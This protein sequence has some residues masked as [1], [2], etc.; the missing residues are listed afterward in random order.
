MIVLHNLRP[1]SQRAC[2]VL[3]LVAML[4]PKEPF[5]GQRLKLLAGLLALALPALA[6]AKA[7]GWERSVV[8]VLADND[9][10]DS[11]STGTAFAINDAGHY[12]TNHHVIEL[13]L[14]RSGRVMI[15]QPQGSS[16]P[17]EHLAQVLW[18]S[19]ELDLAILQVASWRVE[20]L[21]LS[22]DEYVEL[23]QEVFAMGFPGA[24]DIF[25]VNNFALQPKN[26]KGIISARR[27]SPIVASGISVD[28]YETDSAI[29]SGNSGGPLIDTC[30]R[31][32]GVNQSK[33]LS[34]LMDGSMVDTSEGT[35][36]AIQVDV[37]KKVLREQ[38]VDFLEADAACAA[39]SAGKALPPWLLGL[40]LLIGAAILVMLYGYWQLRK[41]LPK[42]MKIN[43]QLVSEYWRKKVRENDVDDKVI[44]KDGKKYKYRRDPIT[45]AVVLVEVN[46]ASPSPDANGTGSIAELQALHPKLSNIK[47]HDN[48]SYS[49]GRSTGN[50][51]I[52]AFSDVSNQH[53]RLQLQA[54][55]V[56]LVDLDSTN[57]SFINNRQLTAHET[58][59]LACGNE[60]GIASINPAYRLRFAV[61]QQ[62]HEE[63]A[64]GTQR[65]GAA[66]SLKPKDG[67]TLA[68]I[69]LLTT[70]DISIGRGAKCTYSIPQDYA[71]VSRQH[72]RL[73]VPNGQRVELIDTSTN[74]VWVNGRRLKANTWV[75]LSIGDELSLGQDSKLTW[76][77]V[78]V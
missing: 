65:L 43:S 53:A 64:G 68:A 44:S 71:K 25:D 14:A 32:V 24:S 36:W 1:R 48:S 2:F 73:R 61:P 34:E 62:A 74:G 58:N 52:L 4:R 10:S 41:S 50:A 63:G 18:H 19:L 69:K 38:G 6:L 15:L 13:G 21:I 70:G 55:K 17:Q 45:G 11:F 16:R 47:L 28:A 33:A 7:D 49:L 3:K 39:S 75:S 57:G 30:G 29:N 27:R 26:S 12:V 31:V 23:R 5:G 59:E 76:V 51:I 20:P 56:T 40:L 60:I 54:G 37:L 67:N 77:L 46:D 72:C 42:N 35:A 66:Y 8:R 22:G 9:K 78:I